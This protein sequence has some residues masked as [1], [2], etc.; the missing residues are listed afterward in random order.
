MSGRLVA[1]TG[2]IAIEGAAGS[3]FYTFADGVIQ[4]SN[5]TES[6]VAVTLR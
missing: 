6:L 2:W 5:V 3:V 1:T 4:W